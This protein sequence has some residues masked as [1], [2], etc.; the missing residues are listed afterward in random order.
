MDRA[1]RTRGELAVDH[2]GDITLRGALRDGPDADG[3]GAQRAEYLR[4]DA[5]RTRHAVA[6]DCEDAAAGIDLDALDLPFAQLAVEGLAHDQLGARRL[7]FRDRE[8]DRVLGAAL[9]DQDDRDA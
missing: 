3:R 5:V 7:P 9:R 2:R 4:R 1:Q 8:A 6:D